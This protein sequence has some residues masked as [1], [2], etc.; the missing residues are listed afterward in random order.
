MQSIQYFKRLTSTNI[1]YVCVMWKIILLGIEI[2]HFG[3][4]IS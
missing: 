2:A 4:G 1:V 3:T